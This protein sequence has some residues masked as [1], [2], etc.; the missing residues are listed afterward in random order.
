MASASRQEKVHQ[1]KDLLDK[2]FK[3]RYSTNDFMKLL[4]S[5]SF[6][7]K[8]LAS[9]RETLEGDEA[10]CALDMAR[11][12]WMRKAGVATRKAVEEGKLKELTMVKYRGML[13][14]RG[15]A[16]ESMEAAYGTECLPVIL[17]SDGHVGPQ[18]RTQRRGYY[19]APH[20]EG[21]LD[22]ARQEACQ[23]GVQQ[24]CQV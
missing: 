9:A 4:R 6:I 3:G 13:V 5:T 2:R 21:V 7:F 11:V 1:K 20:Q 23:E 24:L 8:W 22:R 17:A 14:I 10:L 12:Y 19:H 15:R 16:A 18:P